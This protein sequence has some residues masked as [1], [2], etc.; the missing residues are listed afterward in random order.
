VLE[1]Y[2]IGSHAAA[3]TGRILDRDARRYRSYFPGVP[4]VT[5]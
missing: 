3:L 1:D 4:L 2:F 5:P